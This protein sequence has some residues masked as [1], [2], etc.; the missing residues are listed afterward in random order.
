MTVR[1]AARCA[2]S[3]FGR[4]ART[5]LPSAVLLSPDFRHAV[6]GVTGVDYANLLVQRSTD[7]AP[8]GTPGTP[9]HQVLMQIAYGDHQVSMYS[10]AVEART[11]GA[12]AVEIWDSG[13]GHT[14][15]PPLTNTP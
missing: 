6:L 15:P 10:G 1:L 5:A 12:S 7:F 11:V 14:S 13:P 8:F 3:G 9:A 4:W 2:R